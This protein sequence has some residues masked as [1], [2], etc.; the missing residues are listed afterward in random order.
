MGR[1]SVGLNMCSGTGADEGFKKGGWRMREDLEF[2]FGVRK[3]R[4][5]TKV[6]TSDESRA[7][8]AWGPCALIL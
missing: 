1:A 7:Q 8:A 6:A 5:L 3:L 2:G 4:K